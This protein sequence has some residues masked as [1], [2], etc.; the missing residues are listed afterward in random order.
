MSANKSCSD[1]EA[2]KLGTAVTYALGYL[3][4]LAAVSTTTSERNGA[5]E[6]GTAIREYIARANTKKGEAANKTQSVS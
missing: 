2:L 5:R 6:A 4:A 1:E 3:D